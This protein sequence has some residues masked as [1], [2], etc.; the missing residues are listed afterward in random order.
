MPRNKI[1]DWSEFE[2]ETRAIR[3]G[4]VRGHENEHS[5]AIFAT[6][7]F[8][9]ED[10][11]VAAAKFEPDS[12]GNVYSRFTNPTVRTFQDRLASL[13]GGESCLA[14]ASGMSAI[15]LTCMGVL[16]AGDHVVCSRSVFGSISIF[17]SK[18]MSRFGISCDFVSPIDIDAWEKAAKPNTRM[19]F[20]ETPSNPLQELIDIRQLS[21]LAHKKNS[22]LVVDN[23]FC[24][25]ILQRP[26]SLGADIVVYTATKYI[27]GQGRCVGGAV[28]GDKKRV[29][30]EMFSIMRTVGPAMSPFNAWVFLKGLETLSLRMNAIS[31]RSLELAA[32]LEKRVEVEQ[33][34]YTGLKSHPQYELAQTQQVA[35]G[36]IVSF[37]LKGGLRQAWKFIDATE[38]M[39]LSANLGD[40]KT[41]ITHPAT[42]THGRLTECERQ[43]A[44]ITDN[45]IRIA[46]GLESLNDLK[47]DIDKGFSVLQG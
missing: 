18:I 14:T 7:S 33:V 1:T 16:K 44:G 2:D 34:F 39:S 10:A 5:E 9:F 31:E 28:V 26:I 25:P 4:H 32:W 45:L 15:L 42:T 29:G 41:I 8:I 19:F 40:V 20:A 47:A 30:E 27:D 37:R 35:G 3:A 23:G 21:E 38:L 12:K 11:Q 17:F 46:V 36:G 22:L 24:T 13:D 6:S 43:D